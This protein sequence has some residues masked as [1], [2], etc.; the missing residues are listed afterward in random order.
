[1]PEPTLA[2]RVD[3]SAQLRRRQ[4]LARGISAG[5][6]RVHLEGLSSIPATGPVL[7]AVNH[8]SL[9]DGPLLFGAV[10]RPVS[11]LVK[12]E[13]FTPWAGPLLRS[14]G[15]IAVRRDGGDAPSVRLCLRTLRAGGIV[16]IF[17][18]GTRGHGLVETAKPGVGYLALR[19][20]ATVIPVA[21]S[22]TS[23]MAH[24]HG[25]RRP[26]AVLLFGEPIGLAR[27]PDG[28]VL[29]RTIAAAATEGIRVALAALVAVADELRADRERGRPTTKTTER[30]RD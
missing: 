5:L 2:E 14:S 8:R 15:Q 29:K 26:S 18:E 13:A 28:Q 1:M 6:G 11:C 7:L 27:W 25:W 17:P 10:R 4:G 12:V 20:G 3:G 22:G 24:R 30:A 23:E 9:L 16:G 21:C 19:S